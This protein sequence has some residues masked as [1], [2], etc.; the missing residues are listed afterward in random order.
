MPDDFKHALSVSRVYLD[1]SGVEHVPDTQFTCVPQLPN[2]GLGV[3]DIG[4]AI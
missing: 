1:H 4:I 2:L 3:I